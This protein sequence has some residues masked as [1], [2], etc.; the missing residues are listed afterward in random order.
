MMILGEEKLKISLVVFD[1]DGTLVDTMDSYANYAASLIERYYSVDFNRARKLYMDTSGLPFIH[2]LEQI[3]PK[4]SLNPYIS[5]L[6]EGWK[7]GILKY[8]HQL[9][10][11]ACDAIKELINKD[12]VVCISSNNL[13]ENVNKVVNRWEVKFNAALGY[14][15]DDFQKGAV[16]FKWLEQKF[17]F[18]RTQMI[19]IGD[20]PN[21]YK[22]ACAAGV[23]F[24]AITS[25][26]G[27]EI[28]LSLDREI[29][30]FYD[31]ESMNEF[32]FS[33]RG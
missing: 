31:F 27:R 20:S 8:N 33:Q 17:G 25:T 10:F 30:C 16:H 21:D 23:P 7:K 15:Y 1:M 5:Y 32:I 18:T 13:Q 4:N 11:G 3:F 9:R 28:F 6:F 2:Q 14:K 26:F 29:P 22:L 24:A 12:L 19:F